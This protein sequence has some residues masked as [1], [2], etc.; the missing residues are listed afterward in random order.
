[1]NLIVN[2]LESQFLIALSKD[3]QK[4]DSV[5]QDIKLMRQLRNYGPKSKRR[6][7]TVGSS[8][9]GLRSPWNLGTALLIL[10]N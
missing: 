6:R 7:V 2:R 3:H 5:L 9:N 10:S 1:M 4:L 8:K